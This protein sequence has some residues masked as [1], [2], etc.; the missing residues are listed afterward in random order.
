MLLCQ[1]RHLTPVQDSGSPS[2][3]V[4]L[5]VLQMMKLTSRS[6]LPAG[7]KGKNGTPLTDPNYRHADLPFR[8]FCGR[9][10]AL[11]GAFGGILYDGRRSCLGAP[12]RSHSGRRR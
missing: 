7:S 2:G 12:P 6:L 9:L 3:D 1:A 4:V 8:S 11:G 10:K 5:L